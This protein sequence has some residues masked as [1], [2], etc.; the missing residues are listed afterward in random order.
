MTRKRS[1]TITESLAAA[2]A[3]GRVRVRKKPPTDVFE[4][5]HPKQIDLMNFNVKEPELP[6]RD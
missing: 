6:P 3:E 5:L 4:R 1:K 2:V